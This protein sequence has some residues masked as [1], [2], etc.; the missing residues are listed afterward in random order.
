MIDTRVYAIDEKDVFEAARTFL[1]VEGFLVAPESA[2]AVRA[3]IDEAIDAKR[4]NE[5]KVIVFNVSGMGHLDFQAYREVL[6]DI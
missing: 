4:K 6:K 1:Q 5:E 3:A 2:Y